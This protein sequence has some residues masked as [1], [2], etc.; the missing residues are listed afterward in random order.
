MISAVLKQVPAIVIVCLYKV[1]GYI[2]LESY[3][4]SVQLCKMTA[5]CLNILAPQITR[6]GNH[7]Q[8]HLAIS[9]FEG[10]TFEGGN[11][12][13]LSFMWKKTTPK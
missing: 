3:T 7:Q 8:G 13:V 12:T 9:I 1:K 6:R 2:M 5:I 4:D 10:S 11:R